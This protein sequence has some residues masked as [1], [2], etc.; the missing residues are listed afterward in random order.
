MEL[1]AAGVAIAVAVIIM[2]LSGCYY[3]YRK[4]QGDNAAHH[5]VTSITRSLVSSKAG[6]D[7]TSALLRACGGDRKQAE[8]LIRQEKQKAAGISHAEAVRRALQRLLENG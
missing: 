1:S 8:R 5:D 4:R 3:V 2:A 7:R 6:A